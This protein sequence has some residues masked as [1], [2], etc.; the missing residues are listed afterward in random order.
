VARSCE[1]IQF[2]SSCRLLALGACRWQNVKECEAKINLLAVIVITRSL[3]SSMNRLLAGAMRLAS[4]DREHCIEI[5]TPR[6][7]AKLDEVFNLM[8]NRLRLHE[9]ALSLA[10]KV[11]GLTDLD[12]HREFERLLS[13]QILRGRYA[14]PSA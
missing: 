6:E 7:L 1:S 10:A 4:C 8:T 11:D 5:Q 12:N 3:V 9:E 14:G 2:R 13:E